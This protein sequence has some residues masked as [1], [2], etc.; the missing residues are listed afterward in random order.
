[1]PSLRHKESNL[2]LGQFLFWSQVKG[3]SVPIKLD[4]KSNKV[5]RMGKERD[6]DS[7]SFNCYQGY[8]Y[9]NKFKLV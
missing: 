1:M 7:R 4:S 6:N 9:L 5:Q 2:L 8:Q 3:H